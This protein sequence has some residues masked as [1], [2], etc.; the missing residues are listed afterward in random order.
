[1]IPQVLTIA[2]SDSGGGAGIQADLKTFQEL[3]VFGTSVITAVTAQNTTGVQAVYPMSASAVESQLASI[4][5][6]FTISA[7]KTGMLFDHEIIEVVAAAVRKYGFRKLV[8][9]PVMIAKGGASLLQEKAVEALVQ[10]LIPLAKVITPNIP[11][12]EVLTGE[13]IRNMEDRLRAAD[14]LLSMGAECVILKGGHAEES[15]AWDLVVRG[16]EKYVVKSNRLHTQNTHGTGCTFS[17]ALTAE[18]AKGKTIRESAYLAKCFIYQAIKQDLH[19]GNGHGPTNHWAY[20]ESAR[21]LTGGG[22]IVEPV[23]LSRHS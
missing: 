3:N 6:D 21:H 18:L 19:I 12:A 1:M 22:V 5:N 9:D 20:Q 4:G 15:D 8:V 13:S 14:D 17:A 16:T 10:K 7:V 23:V 2:G 11:E